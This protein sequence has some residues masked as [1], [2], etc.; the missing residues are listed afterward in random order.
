MSDA[1]FREPAILFLPFSV[2][3]D[4]AHQ[5]CVPEGLW[6]GAVT[7][8]QCMSQLVWFF[9]LPVAFFWSVTLAVTGTKRSLEQ[10]LVDSWLKFANMMRTWT[11]YDS[12]SVPC[13]IQCMKNSLLIKS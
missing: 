7:W 9:H 4:I 12:K 10:K 13:I 3:R 11:C 8:C 1:E 2:A 5:G 6:T